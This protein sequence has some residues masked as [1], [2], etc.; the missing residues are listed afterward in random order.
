MLYVTTR[1]DR[2][3]FT[4]QRALTERRGADGGLYVPFHAPAFSP[5]E[6][7]SLAEKPMN[8]CVAEV[9][10][11]LF[12]TQLTRWDVDLCTGKYP[13]RLSGLSH[14]ILVGEC[15]HN[16]DGCFSRMVQNLTEQIRSEKDPGTLPGEWAAV[17]VRIAMLAGICGELMRRGFVSR[18]KHFDISL[19]SGDLSAAISA[20]YAREWGLPIGNIIC[21]CNENNSM[22]ELLR[23]G[24]LRTDGVSV[25]TQTPEADVVVPEGLERLIH[26]CGG[27]EAVERYLDI[28]RRG[29]TYYP[30]DALL[31]Q[32]RRG[33]YVAVVSGRRMLA[34]IP[35]IYS[36]NGYV[37]SPYASLAY[38]GLLDYRSRTGESRCALVLSEK[39]PEKDLDTVAAALGITSRELKRHLEQ[40]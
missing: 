34:T 1:N 38:A 27:V 11:L 5:E 35:S 12:H 7:D 28:C 6:I 20:W 18:E 36:T 23:Q 30:D 22:W 15:W 33:M 31:E 26:G 17:G 13:V 16:V 40:N 21:C 37:L 4:A 39:S 3:A 25:T 2:D 29:G 19:V 9:A 24:Q 32:L 10:N 8:A 14:R